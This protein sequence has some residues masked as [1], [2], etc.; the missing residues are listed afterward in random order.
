MKKQMIEKL[1]AWSENAILAAELKGNSLEEY[2]NPG[3]ES[4]RALITESHKMGMSVEE[5]GELVWTPYA[6]E[7]EYL[8]YTGE[9]SQS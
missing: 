1:K 4:L 9:E 8:N 7:V 2:A 3:V 6:N 5:I